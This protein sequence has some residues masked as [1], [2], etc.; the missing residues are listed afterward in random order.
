MSRKNPRCKC[1]KLWGVVY[2]KIKQKCGRCRTLVKIR[3][4]KK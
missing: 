2:M 4:F 3:E 1:G